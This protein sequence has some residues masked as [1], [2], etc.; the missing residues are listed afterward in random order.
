[1]QKRFTA[2]P[3]S[4]VLVACICDIFRANDGVEVWWVVGKIRALI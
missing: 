3:V 1:M 4:N 2:G